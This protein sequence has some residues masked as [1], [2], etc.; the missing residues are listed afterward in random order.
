[1]KKVISIAVA[2]LFAACLFAESE[3][4]TLT[5]SKGREKKF[6][7]I[8]AALKGVKGSGE[9][10][11]KLPKG[12]YNEILY[13]NGG[14]KITISGD[15]DSEFGSDV[16]IAAENNGELKKGKSMEG[17]A[18]KDRCL[19]EFEGT[20]NL[21]LE[22][23]TLHNT[24]VK[25]SD[26]E[27][28]TQAEAL[29]FD[30]TGNLAAYNCSFKSYQ[31]TVRTTGK[32]WFYGCLIEGDVDFIWMEQTGKVALY[33]KCQIRSIYNPNV[34]SHTAYICAPRTNISGLISKGIVIFDSEI[35]GAEKEKTYLART[36]WKEGYY[37]QV[38][39]IR[40][41]ASGIDSA[42]WHKEPLMAKNT[43]RTVIGWKMDGKT[44]ES[45][46]VSAEGRNDILDE[47]T[48]QA[49][50][51]GR[52]VI[53][54]KTVSTSGIYKKES[55]PWNVSEMAKKLGWRVTEDLSQL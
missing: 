29:G 32:A 16:I 11:I 44:A 2:A 20:G 41:A 24:Y 36:P 17:K 13:Y 25:K 43:P 49:E 12:T 10:K 23:L 15:T 39:Y 6:D 52:N 40:C 5:D 1:M 42:I 26:G 4:I 21:T 47:A 46:G 7:T 27:K 19:F 34:S 8:A 35:S 18:I 50:Y 55:K 22:N 31:D 14:A 38:A 51:G 54:N 45:L 30:S 3:K 53:L 48:V 37:S 33:E 28:N 9:Y